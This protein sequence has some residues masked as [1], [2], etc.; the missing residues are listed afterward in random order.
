MAVVVLA[1]VAVAAGRWGAEDLAVAVVI[2]AAA[3]AVTL[4]AV[5]VTLVA[6]TSAAGIS[7][8]PATSV[9]IAASMAIA[10]SAAIATL[11]ALADSTGV[12]GSTAVAR[13]MVVRPGIS[14]PVALQAVPE[15]SR[16]PTSSGS[17]IRA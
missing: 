3:V 12:A 9:A 5:A 8:E 16:G 6:G 7:V 4:V 1:A 15:N 13:S 11:A 14:A 10:D 2:L 17:R